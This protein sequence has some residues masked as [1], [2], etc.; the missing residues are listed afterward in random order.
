MNS[1]SGTRK[2]T[3]NDPGDVGPSLAG[4]ML[5]RGRHRQ[6]LVYCRCDHPSIAALA[7]LLLQ[8]L[9]RKSVARGVNVEQ[10]LADSREGQGYSGDC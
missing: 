2:L 5:M 1:Q 3:E 10:E 8:A 6:C 9:T 4:S 7:L